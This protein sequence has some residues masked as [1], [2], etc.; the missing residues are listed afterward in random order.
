[1][2]YSPSN[3]LIQLPTRRRPSHAHRAFCSSSNPSDHSA[4]QPQM[5]HTSQPSTLS[6]V[7]STEGDKTAGSR[8]RLTVIPSTIKRPTILQGP[9]ELCYALGSKIP[10]SIQRD[11]Q[12]KSDDL[13]TKIRVGW[14]DEQTMAR[15]RRR[16]SSRQYARSTSSALSTS[17]QNMI[18]RRTSLV[19][20]QKRVP[21]SSRYCPKQQAI[22]A[23]NGR[24][25]EQAGSLPGSSELDMSTTI[26]PC[27]MVSINNKVVL[28]VDTENCFDPTRRIGQWKLLRMH[29]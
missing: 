4:A 8:L 9:R 6:V 7:L 21:N 12:T 11:L 20:R 28:D 26:S 3:L 14:G 2:L 1:M 16:T 13:Y 15:S 22:S 29:R 27:G 25:A 18:P 23:S 24:P 5:A 10:S 19:C 17:S